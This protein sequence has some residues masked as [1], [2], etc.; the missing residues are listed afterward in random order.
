M[1]GQP[2]RTPVFAWVILVWV[3]LGALALA[4]GY[5]TVLGLVPDVDRQVLAG[6]RAI[7][8]PHWLLSALGTAANLAGAVLLV[9]RRALAA[10]VFALALAFI[11]AD[12]TWLYASGHIATVFPHAGPMVVGIAIAAMI[13]GYAYN[14]KARGRIV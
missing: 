12:T 3:V 11:L 6:H 7:G 14:L 9:R 10:P 1:T 4:A 5:A 8:W 13:V 2:A